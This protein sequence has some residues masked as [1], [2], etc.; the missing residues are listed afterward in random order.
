MEQINQLQD[1]IM[2]GT[3]L[4]TENLIGDGICKNL[5]RIPTTL[6]KIVIV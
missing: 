6:P 3:T 5:T 4:P 1:S 2:T